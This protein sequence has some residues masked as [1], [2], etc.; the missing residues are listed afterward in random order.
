[1]IPH[2]VSRQSLELTLL[3]TSKLRV[4]IEELGIPAEPSFLTTICVDSSHGRRLTAPGC[5]SH[6]EEVVTR[7]T[8][9]VHD[10]QNLRYNHEC[11][12]RLVTRHAERRLA[13]FRIG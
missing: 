13:L 8:L 12:C 11:H 10:N 4:A 7:G 1:M 5:L 3:E 9:L 2:L 6:R